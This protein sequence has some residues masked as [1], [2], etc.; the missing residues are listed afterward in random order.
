M[1]GWTQSVCQWVK[2][3]LGA[4]D[5]VCL[6]VLCCNTAIGGILTYCLQHSDMCGTLQ[7]SCSKHHYHMSMHHIGRR[8]HHATKS[9]T[10]YTARRLPSSSQSTLPDAAQISRS[11]LNSRARYLH[12]TDENMQVVSTCASDSL[13]EHVH[14]TVGP[15]TGGRDIR[16]RVDST[17]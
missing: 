14:N 5:C 10:Q 13:M 15:N 17:G 11:T 2:T 7:N 4:L 8:L 12:L 1:A 3:V 9:Q 16:C 6:S